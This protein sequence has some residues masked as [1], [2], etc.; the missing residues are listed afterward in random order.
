[1]FND[2]FIIQ[3]LPG[4]G[5]SYETHKVLSTLSTPPLLIEGSTSL[6]SFGIDLATAMYLNQGNRT[7]VVLD[8]CDSLFDNANINT[9]KGMFGTSKTFSYNKDV[10][11]LYGTMTELNRQ[12]V[13]H[14]A[15]PERKGFRLPLDNVTVIIL[16]NIHMPTINEVTSAKTVAKQTELGHLHAIRRRVE[17]KFIDM[18]LMELW[19]YVANITLNGS[20]CEKF[21]PSI[22]YEQ[23]VQLAQWCYSNWDSMTERNLS[24]VEKMT[25]DIVRYPN[26]YMDI[27]QQEYLE[28]TK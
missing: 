22:T 24:I 20:I 6:S 1:V 12:A 17:Y 15:D 25:K 16:T 11:R 21:I 7:T 3:S 19:G 14:F 10:K 9:M 27:W 8:D 4:L 5:K 26:N 23:K 28:K 13:E 18:E 2:N